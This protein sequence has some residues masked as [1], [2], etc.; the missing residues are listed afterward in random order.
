MKPMRPSI[1]ALAIAGLMAAGCFTYSPP[2]PPPTSMTAWS[3]T[4][5]FSLNTG[6]SCVGRVTLTDGLATVTDSCFSG[7]FD[8]VVC[9]DNTLPNPVRCTSSMGS[10]AISGTGSD[11][12]S[13]ARLK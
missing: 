4:G 3:P 6:G 1:L 7:S 8:V 10:L 2:P 12:V 5:G 9:T 11:S 13:Y